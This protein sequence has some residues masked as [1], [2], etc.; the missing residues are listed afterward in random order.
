[1]RGRSSMTTLSIPRADI[2][3]QTVFDDRPLRFKNLTL[4]E[5]N[6]SPLDDSAEIHGAFKI[7]VAK[8][9]GARREAITLVQRRYNKRGYQTPGPKRD[10]YLS[11][12]VAYDEGQIVGT[13]G[14]RLDAGK[15]LSAD[16][17]YRQEIDILRASGSL[18]CEFTRLA[19]DSSAASKPVLAG[20]FHTA[21]LY[22]SVI[23]GCTH[24]VIEVNPRHVAYYERALNFEPIGPERMNARVQAPAVLLC[25]PFATIAEGLAKFAGKMAAHGAR[26]SLFLYGF[27]PNEEVGV[28]KRLRE[29]VAS[30]QAETRN[31]SSLPVQGAERKIGVF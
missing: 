21:Y 19:V 5:A 10:P 6:T 1:M 16:D 30:N 13:V 7:R 2:T 23:N 29:L 4:T 20:L 14:V 28:L 22:A 11:T 27:P 9:I 17:L 3:G 25:V 15:G 12:F 24:A 8:H 31:A 26:R 18:M